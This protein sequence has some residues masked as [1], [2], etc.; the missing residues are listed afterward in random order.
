MK[1]NY[2]VI[3]L[4]LF[5]A[6]LN[7]CSEYEGIDSDTSFLNTAGSANQ[8][9]IFEISDDNSGNVKITPQG[10]G[11][12]KSIVRF[13]HGSASASLQPGESTTYAYP[14]GS[15][16]VSIDYVDIAGKTTT[17]TYPLTVTY[18]APENL[19]VS[20]SGEAKVKATAL[21]AKSFLVY[22]GDVA[23]ETPTPLAIDQELPPHTY[24]ENGGPFTLRVV[25][26]SGGAATTSSSK[27]LFGF[28][29]DFE[30]P[31][32]NY[33]FG[34]FGGGQQFA[35]VDNPNKSGLNSSAK[36]GKFTRGYEWWSGTY[37]PLNIPI[38]FAYG[39]KIK[40]WVYNPNEAN[41]GK[42]MNVEL[43]WSINGP[44]NGVAV[45][46]SPVTKHGEWEE[47]E[48]DFGSIAAIPADTKF[49]QLVLRFNDSQDGTFDEIYVDNFRL[50]K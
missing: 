38:N 2:K 40:V 5:A 14:E 47:L 17:S 25:A 33:F 39:N 19:V 41:V 15:Y 10:D 27:T 4:F 34:T 44:A 26:L 36:V 20:I 35:T 11:V 18:R 3:A 43:E 50:T 45:L 23:N 46:K 6:I 32:V 31:E 48:F 12:S 37:S 30:H 7:G 13:G 42:T 28:P 24:P 49:T 21:F 22:Y 16:T 1:F 29:I 9:K 8:S